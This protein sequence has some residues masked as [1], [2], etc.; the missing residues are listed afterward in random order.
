[1][2]YACNRGGENGENVISSEYGGGDIRVYTYTCR[3]GWLASFAAGSYAPGEGVKVT[4]SKCARIYIIIIMCAASREISAWERER[5]NPAADITRTR[6]RAGTALFPPSKRQPSDRHRV[7]P[8]SAG[9][10]R[11]AAD[12]AL[13]RRRR[14]RTRRL[15]G[16]GGTQRS[17]QLSRRANDGRVSA[18]SSGSYPVGRNAFVNVRVRPR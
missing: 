5:G 6:G 16:V 15:A 11:V 7:A 14:R 4:R 3:Q 9:A 17:E 18:K 8:R 13:S 10:G 1:M 12:S 2:T